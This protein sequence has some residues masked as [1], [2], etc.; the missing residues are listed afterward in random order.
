MRNQEYFLTDDDFG[1][2]VPNPDEG[3]IMNI[4]KHKSIK[5]VVLPTND[6]Y[7]IIEG[8]I[9]TIKNRNIKMIY[10]GDSII[11]MDTRLQKNEWD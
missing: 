1:D 9:L 6:N 4:K 11:I 10:T 2:L 8:D 7:R 3:K 5:I